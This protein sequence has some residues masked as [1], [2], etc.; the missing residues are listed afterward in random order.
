MCTW[1]RRETSGYVVGDP[2]PTA[3][4]AHVRK[5][6]PSRVPSQPSPS[7]PSCVMQRC[8]AVSLYSSIATLGRSA[9]PLNDHHHHD[10]HDRDDGHDDA[11]EGVFSRARNP[12]IGKRTKPFHLEYNTVPLE[13]RAYNVGIPR[14]RGFDSYVQPTSIAHI[15]HF[16]FSDSAPS[17]ETR[18][19]GSGWTSSHLISY[20]IISYQGGHV[21]EDRRKS[22]DPE[23]EGR[24]YAAENRGIRAARG[25]PELARARRVQ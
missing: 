14:A 5:P 3:W 25:W 13:K 7:L 22:S 19:K 10:H 23:L 16:L 15:I 9:R 8:I 18:S 12:S 20:N 2:R 4:S 17:E 24:S 21:M 1:T 6:I 11:V